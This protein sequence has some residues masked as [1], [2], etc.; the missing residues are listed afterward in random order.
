M[1]DWQLSLIV[2]RSTPCDLAATSY[3]E[4]L[5]IAI[6][7]GLNNESVRLVEDVIMTPHLQ[8]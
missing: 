2:F 6:Q 4:A 5:E 8:L 7:L 1:L 3:V